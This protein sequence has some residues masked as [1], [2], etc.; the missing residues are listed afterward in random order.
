MAWVTTL[1][2]GGGQSLAVFY[3]AVKVSVLDA[4]R[5]VVDRHAAAVAAVRDAVLRTPGAADAASRELAFAGASD[6][7]PS[8]SYIAKV[9]EASYRV[10]DADI[11][12]LG[13][14]GLSEDAIFELTLAAALGAAGRRLDAGLRALREA[15]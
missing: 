12:A 14:A 15:G 8:A 7:A 11:E 4:G 5:M 3:L 1:G 13:A 10:T 2:P 6:D 9:H